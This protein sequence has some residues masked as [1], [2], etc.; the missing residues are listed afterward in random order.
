MLIAATLVMTAFLLL[1]GLVLDNAF[2]SSARKAMRDRLQGHIYTLLAAAEPDKHG[3]LQVPASLPEPRFSTI[4]SGLYAEII[5]D[6]KK[7]LWRSPSALGIVAVFKKKTRL[8][9]NVYERIE[10]KK[11]N[12]YYSLSFAI[13]QEVKGRDRQYLFRVYE[14]LDRYTGQVQKFR[15]NM[16]IW[17]GAAAVL[18]L[19]IQALIIRWGMRPLVRV[20]NDLAEV[21]AGR[22]EQLT[23]RYPADLHSLT[24]NLNTLIK[25]SRSHLQRYR[26]SLGNLAHSLKTP[27]AVLQVAIDDDAVTV[28]EMKRTAQEQIDHM[29]GIV[30]YQ[31]HRASASGRTALSKPVIVI[32][33]VTRIVSALQKVH[34]SKNIHCDLEIAKDIVFYG[35]EDD[36]MEV[37]GNLVDNAYKWCDQKVRISAEAITSLDRQYPGLMLTIEDDGP[38]VPGELTES[39]RQRGQRADTRVP[40]HGLGL[41]MVQDTLQIYNGSLSITDSDLGGARFEVCFE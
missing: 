25:S 19:L 39:I 22:Q 18:L 37:L 33:V 7:Q 4:G 41:A 24:D 34:A 38:G 40:G 8:G 16:L 26:D 1:T 23:G 3:I 29:H 36:L 12:K 30:E 28:D 11:S 17:F 5:T 35:D 14:S 2:R 27:I 20:S 6:Q 10:D 31:L 15:N 21:E 13:V 32:G 9:K